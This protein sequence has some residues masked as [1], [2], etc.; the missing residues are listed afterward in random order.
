VKDLYNKYTQDNLK[1]KDRS[2]KG[3]LTRKLVSDLKS[4]NFESIQDFEEKY[5]EYKSNKIKLEIENFRFNSDLRYLKFFNVDMKDFAATFESI[6]NNKTSD[7][8]ILYFAPKISFWV[9]QGE[10]NNLESQIKVNRVEELGL[11]YVRT[12]MKHG[13]VGIG[14]PGCPMFFFVG[15]GDYERDFWL[16]VSFQVT[17]RT[18]EILGLQLERSENNDLEVNGKKMVGVAINP[19]LVG[20]M[21]I[22]DLD[23]DLTDTVHTQIKYGAKSSDRMTSAKIQLGHEITQE[24]FEI[25]LKQAVSEILHTNIYDGE[26]DST[27]ISLSNTLKSKYHS[28]EWN[29]YGN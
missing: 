29:L 3:D 5:K 12:V 15:R 18:Y 6:V 7:T 1:L 14:G 21:S 28:R 8:L 13:S 25:A 4:L 11:P 10:V 17:L 20:V 22:L 9:T 2:K 27:E 16:E 19:D 23:F 26:L 24:E